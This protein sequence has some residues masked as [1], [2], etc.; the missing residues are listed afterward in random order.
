MPEWLRL[1]SH[2]PHT[3]DQKQR[4]GKGL[5]KWFGYAKNDNDDDINDSPTHSNVNETETSTT[6][7][8]PIQRQARA[9]PVALAPFAPLVLSGGVTLGKESFK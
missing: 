2:S 5:A 9:L 8:T 4:E 3:D 6:A 7:M 1:D